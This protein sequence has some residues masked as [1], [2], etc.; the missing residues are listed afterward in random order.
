MKFRE[1]VHFC[2]AGGKLEKSVGTDEEARRRNVTY[3]QND[4]CSH[5]STSVTDA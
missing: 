1:A 2:R 3:R 4:R 5:V